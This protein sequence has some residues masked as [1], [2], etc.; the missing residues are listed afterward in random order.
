MPGLWPRGCAFC[1]L[2][3]RNQHEPLHPPVSPLI[4]ILDPL[5]GLFIKLYP[6][7]LIFKA[8]ANH[9]ALKPET[10]DYL[11]RIA[12]ESGK[13]VIA[14]LTQELLRDM[15]RGLPRY[16]AEPKLLC[17]G[18]HEISFVQKQMKRWH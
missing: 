5:I 14:H 15:V 2:L 6:G 18:D 13:Q 12:A 3:S 16:T 10:R 17:H 4:I 7:R 11:E 1:I 8:F 9:R